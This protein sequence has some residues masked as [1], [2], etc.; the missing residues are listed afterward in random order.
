MR[1]STKAA[2]VVVGAASALAGVTTGPVQ[3][4]PAAEGPPPVVAEDPVPLAAVYSS[5]RGS[6]AVTVEATAGGGRPFD[7]GG[8]ADA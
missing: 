5:T 4:P 6:I 8:Q 1:R 7:P 3:D 2:L